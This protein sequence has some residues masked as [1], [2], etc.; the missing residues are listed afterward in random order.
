[1]LCWR[2]CVP[3]AGQNLEF[4]AF[5]AQQDQGRSVA[6]T[7]DRIARSYR[8]LGNIVHERHHGRGGGCS[9]FWRRPFSRRHDGCA[10]SQS[11]GLPAFRQAAMP[12]RRV[13]NDRILRHELP[14]TIEMASGTLPGCDLSPRSALHKI[15]KDFSRVRRLRRTTVT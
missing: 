12:R 14:D 5:T 13:L 3:A 10:Q 2:R 15:L 8:R 9:S 11:R 7:H 4:F 1:M 6:W